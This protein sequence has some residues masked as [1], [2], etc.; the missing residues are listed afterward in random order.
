M[1]SLGFHIRSQRALC[2]P[3]ADDSNEP[4]KQIRL[5]SSTA[6]YYLACVLY[7]NLLIC[8]HLTNGIIT[9]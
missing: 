7:E 3:S 8:P 2:L 9:S 1:N 6:T 5:T 4:P